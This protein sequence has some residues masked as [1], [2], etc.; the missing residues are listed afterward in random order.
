[1]PEAD[2]GKVRVGAHG[3]K[4]NKAVVT[5]IKAG[6]FSVNDRQDRCARHAWGVAVEE[7]F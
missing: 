7:I 3:S 1:M 2:R 5:L 6:G 4:F